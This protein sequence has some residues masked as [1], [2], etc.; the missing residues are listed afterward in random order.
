MDSASVLHLEVSGFGEFCSFIFLNLVF[1][2]SQNTSSE[3]L[4]DKTPAFDAASVKKLGC[5]TNCTACST[6][7]NA[8]ASDCASSRQV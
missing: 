5:S 2:P 6:T 7:H 3:L 4:L 8:Q 1:L